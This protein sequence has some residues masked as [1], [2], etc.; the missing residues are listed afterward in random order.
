M[1][2]SPLSVAISL[3]MAAYGAREKTLK[4]L[5]EVLYLPS[6]DSI[7]KSGFSVLVDS[8]NVSLEKMSINFNLIFK[9]L[10]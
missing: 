2:S 10:I 5:R 1:I 3:S 9:N 4:E 8:L 6:N 7:A